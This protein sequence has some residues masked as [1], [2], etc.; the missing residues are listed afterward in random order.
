VPL[1]AFD[2]IFV[3]LLGYHIQEIQPRLPVNQMFRVVG[4]FQV[5]TVSYLKKLPRHQTC[6]VI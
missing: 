4:E 6:V 3:I 5:A 1:Q 2:T